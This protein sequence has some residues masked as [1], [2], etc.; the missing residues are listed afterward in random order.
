[1]DEI[2]SATEEFTSAADYFRTLRRI[3]P[4][5][6]QEI[7]PIGLPEHEPDENDWVDV[8]VTVSSKVPPK[9]LQDSGIDTPEKLQEYLNQCLQDLW[10][11]AEL[12]QRHRLVYS[13]TQR[14][15]KTPELYD[16][17]MSWEV[18]KQERLG[19]G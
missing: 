5:I 7:E 13:C 10:K 18:T 17:V 8:N 11:K 4:T 2:L 16:K 15:M 1:M 3:N 12:E 14:L 6:D 9:V 19:V